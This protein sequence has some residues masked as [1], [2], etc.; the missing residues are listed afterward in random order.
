[1]VRDRYA[2]QVPTLSTT[3]VVSSRQPVILGYLSVFDGEDSLV[4]YLSLER[5]DSSKVV[6]EKPPEERRWVGLA[7]TK[8][9]KSRSVCWSQQRRSTDVVNITTPATQSTVFEVKSF[10][11]H[12]VTAFA[13]PKEMVVARTMTRKIVSFGI[14]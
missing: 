11:N 4:Q 8:H 1:L 2:F 5:D 14:Q 12:A 13:V 3:D 6:L 7:L 10:P 9:K